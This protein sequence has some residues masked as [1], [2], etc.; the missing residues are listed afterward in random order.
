MKGRIRQRGLR[1]VGALL[2]V[3][4]LP[5]AV[6]AYWT[7]FLPGSDLTIHQTTAQLLG[8]A[9]LTEPAPRPP[10]IIVHG[11]Q[12][13]DSDY[14]SDCAAADGP[15]AYPTL[16]AAGDYI[17]LHNLG[18]WLIAD[19]YTPYYVIL[20]T[21]PDYTPTFE[22]NGRCLEQQLHNLVARLGNAAPPKFTIIAHSMGGLATRACLA[23]SEFCSAVTERV[24]TLGTP[25]N[26]TNSTLGFK[27]GSSDCGTDPGLCQMVDHE[28]TRAFNAKN[29]NLS[30][31]DYI[32]IGGT[33]GV[34][35]RAY[36]FHENDGLVGA[37]SAIG[38]L[39]DAN[40]Q[41]Q[42]SAWTKPNPPTVYFVN[43]K[44][45]V[46]RRA[47]YA[48]A[49]APAP[50]EISEAYHCIRYALGKVTTR[51]GVCRT[52]ANPRPAILNLGPKV[53]ED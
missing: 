50:G 35:Q 8:A 32:F 49:E 16:L 20:A 47:G 42:W 6:V 21:S 4:L 39:F 48:Y 30:G 51:P 2:L 36:L 38:M 27:T 11:L 25:H 9:Q 52:P 1:L 19:R 41:P 44:H 3:L 29:P 37:W 28:R 5:L 17:P 24:I 26:G 18:P 46:S 12:D 22:E 31:L 45:A 10:I 43:N 23:Q 14:A 15:F 13:G 40:G 34:L 7:L 33:Q 53:M